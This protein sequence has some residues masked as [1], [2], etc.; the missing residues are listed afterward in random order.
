MRRAPAQRGGL[1]RHER[2]WIQGTRISAIKC[3]LLSF[4]WRCCCCCCCCF[5][6]CIRIFSSNKEVY[7]FRKVLKREERNRRRVRET[8]FD[9]GQ[10]VCSIRTI[11]PSPS[12]SMTFLISPWTL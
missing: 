4:H 12:S 3:P 5:Q 1:R 7:K 8:G 11:R 2:R 10:L 6:H 9:L